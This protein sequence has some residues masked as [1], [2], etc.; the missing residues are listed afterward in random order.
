MDLCCASDFV[1]LQPYVGQTGRRG[2]TS[3]PLVERGGKL[4]V[5]S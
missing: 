3:V 4:N 5:L 2:G 1:F